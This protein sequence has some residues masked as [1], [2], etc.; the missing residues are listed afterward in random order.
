[1]DTSSQ[2]FISFAVAVAAASTPCFQNKNNNNNLYFLRQKYISKLQLIRKNNI[3]SRNYLH[4][5][6]KNYSVIKNVLKSV[7]PRDRD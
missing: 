7:D 4:I 6:F 5:I 2:M 3:N 1:M